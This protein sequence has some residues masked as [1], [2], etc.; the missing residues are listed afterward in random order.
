MRTLGDDLI[1]DGD[2]LWNEEM[3]C[4]VKIRWTG[5]LKARSQDWLHELKAA[6]ERSS[7]HI[8]L[9]WTCDFKFI[10]V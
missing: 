5:E 10:W 9:D 4:G 6:V 3:H 1:G 8:C 2:R 7:G